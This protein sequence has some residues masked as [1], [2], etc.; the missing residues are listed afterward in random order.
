M[1][2]NIDGNISNAD[3][4]KRTWDLPRTLNGL[5][6]TYGQNAKGEIHRLFYLPI[7]KSMPK[8][9]IDEIA[10]EYGED[11]IPKFVTRDDSEKKDVYSGSATIVTATP[12]HAGLPARRE[13]LRAIT[14]QRRRM[15]TRRVIRHRLPDSE[16]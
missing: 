8:S 1:A 9:L 7:S 16:K 10:K 13:E 5:I 11:F 4:V 2:I 6:R 12:L 14:R 15:R 3:W